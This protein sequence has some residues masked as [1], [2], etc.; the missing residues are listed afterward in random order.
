MVDGACAVELG[1]APLTAPQD[2]LPSA[3]TAARS[4]VAVVVAVGVLCLMTVE[5][6]ASWSSL[7]GLPE[8]A[9]A[10][11]WGP[12]FVQG[13][14]PTGQIRGAA[15]GERCVPTHAAVRGASSRSPNGARGPWARHS[16]GTG[17]GKLDGPEGLQ[18]NFCTQFLYAIC[19]VF[20]GYPYGIAFAT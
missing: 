20:C 12:H 13:Q 11:P 3:W 18:V 6:P 7:F 15:Q 10:G 1:T 9:R 19:L 17:R 14:G 4:R 16:G 2:R 8:V 5:W